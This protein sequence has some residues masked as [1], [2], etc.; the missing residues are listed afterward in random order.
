MALVV[1]ENRVAPV[2]G[3]VLA[4]NARGKP[5]GLVDLGRWLRLNRTAFSVSKVDVLAKPPAIHRLAEL[6]DR[7]EELDL[8]LSL[9]T[10]CTRPPDSL[11]DLKERGLYDV[12]LCPHSE[13]E[14]NLDLWLA[15]CAELGLPV[16]IQLQAPFAP[17]LDVEALASRLS[18]MGVTAVN[19]AALDPFL[20]KP[21][22]GSA[23]A[24]QKAIEQMNALAE[25]LD[26]CGMEANLLGLPLCL[27]NES[28]RVRC[29]NRPQFFLDHQQYARGSYDL[30]ESLWRSYPVAA[31]KV[32]LALL[33]RNTFQRTFVD[34]VILRLFLHT[35][36][37]QSWLLFWH[38]L[39]RHLR[40][41]R[42]IPK[43]L[44]ASIEAHARDLEKARSRE[45][46]SLGSECGTCS[47]RRICDHAPP[48][49]RRAFPGLSLTVEKGDL[50]MSPMHFARSQPKHY[51]TIDADRKALPEAC[52]H[53]AA[54]ANETTANRPPDLSLAPHDYSVESSPYERL[55]G[56][57]RWHS[58]TNVER[59]SS[60][61]PQLEP[62]FTLSV[63]FGGGIA[64]CIGFSFGRHAR[65][66][67]PMEAYRHKLTL[68]V[69]D[70]GH[71]VLLRD[72]RITRPAELDGPY[73]TPLRLGGRLEPR[74]S[75]WGID[76]SIVTQFVEV[77]HGAEAKE[78]QPSPR[79]SIVLI[80]TRYAR[81]LQAALLSIAHQNDFDLS[82]LEVIVSYVPGL[83]ATDDLIDSM[84][85]T[86]PSLRIVR[87]PFT[88][89]HA[90]AKGFMINESVK[91]ARG[92]WII[93]MDADI[94]LP[95]TLFARI[96]ALADSCDLIA[97][98]GR[99]MLDKHTTGRILLGEIEPWRQWDELV[100]G[101]GEYR[102]REAHGV[103]VG[104]FQCFK[105]SVLERIQYAELEHFEGA[106]MW[107]GMGLQHELGKE[108]RLSGL[109]VLHLD[110]GGSQ[111]Y[112]TQKHF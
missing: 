25:A 23:E 88:D 12:F 6:L 43:T 55:E 94:V 39:K 84:Q 104:F 45:Q 80:N 52:E 44:E 1:S 7:A 74:M 49:F 56:G 38:K 95:P 98:D 35:R 60:P 105:A 36:Y 111:W 75:I 16:R 37:A 58:V 2:R 41:P 34:A 27:V 51:D 3:L 82:A 70:D 107:F 86:F 50:V 10:D 100:G 83:D 24:A 19:V 17:G 53:L 26:A 48:D 108:T 5:F 76:G 69:A 46:R 97:P 32:L 29:L 73:Y 101:A 67:C 109:P 78:D 92:E 99:K 22:C 61:L 64:E 31:G 77:W 91:A 8:R 14:P 90:H 59:L 87:S 89:Q 68:H 66:L 72:G 102:H 15:R 81:R 9:R 96:D 57:V 112:G 85:A 13:K 110:H 63:T 106:D 47:L 40:S 4:Q 103:P 21:S 79:Y 42:E 11:E 71:Y 93:L 54:A 30:A 20:A 62:P 65:V 33:A 18:G 28:N